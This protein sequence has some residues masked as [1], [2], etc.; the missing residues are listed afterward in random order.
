VF[1]NFYD[2]IPWEALKYMVSEAN[3][4]GRVTDPQDR[5]CI[6]LILTDFYNK[7]MLKEGHKLVESGIYYVPPDGQLSS[8]PEFIKETFPINDVTEIFGLHD[9]A[10]ITSAIN[11]TTMML[12][13]AL[14]LLPREIG[15]EGMSED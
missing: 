13:T 7:D 10:N 12:D 1:L 15:G 6:N 8:Y 9:N 2:E 11:Q 14:S 3:Y 4:G 5:R